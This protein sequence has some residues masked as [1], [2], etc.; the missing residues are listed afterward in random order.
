MTSKTSPPE[1]DGPDNLLPP[2][3]KEL[4]PLV[5]RIL[6]EPG[7]SRDALLDEISDGD[8][9]RREE[10]SKIVA[11]CERDSPLLDRPAVESYAG[12]F[13][14]ADEATLT[15]V[16]GDRYRIEREAGRGG[17]ARVFLARD[18][19][20]DRD[21]AVK[22][23]REELA[24]SL[25]SGRFLQEIAIA[26]RLRH[27]NIVPMYDSGEADGVLYFVMP[28]E[29]GPSLG[30]RM[31]Q[32]PAMS[33][34]E[35]ISILRDIARA[36]AYAHER[37]IV[38]RDIKPG[39]VLLT[40]GAAVV[41]DFG[42]AKAV[43]TAQ[44]AASGTNTQAD[45]PIGTPAYM[46]PEQAA[47]DP[48]TDHRADIYSFGCL[49]Y[50]LFS[51]S[52]PFQKTTTQEMATAH[53]GTIPIPILEVCS[54]VSAPVAVLIMSCLNKR[55]AD[56]PQSARELLNILDA[57][58][59]SPGANAELRSGRPGVRRF[60]PVAAAMVLIVTAGFFIVRG[61]GSPKASREL[62]VAVVPIVI[63]RDSTERELAFGLSDEIATALVKEPGVRV[64]SRR[65]VAASNDDSVV[66]PVK[67]G[68]TLGAEYLVTNSL[69]I[70][71]PRLTV[72]T[73]LVQ[74]NNGAILWGERFE[75][76]QSEMA[77]IREDIARSVGDTLRKRSGFSGER[78]PTR[79]S[80]VVAPEPYRLYLL[81]QRGLDSRG[82]S[83]ESSAERFR[84]ATQL[85]TLYAEAYAG[86]S[87]AL[88]LSPYF[89]PVSPTQVAAEA[90]AAARRALQL[91]PTL[92]QPHVALGIIN[93]LAYRW[94]SAGSEFRTGVALRSVS[95]VE[96]LVQFGRY[97][98]FR[99]QPA[100][101]EKQFKL[102][103]NTEPASALVRSWVAYSYYVEGQLDSAII[104]NRRAFQSDST[105]LTT[106]SLGALIL[107]NA[108]DVTGARNYIRRVSPRFHLAFY[109]L[110]ADGDSV[111]AKAR[112]R[113]LEQQRAAPWLVE[114]SRAFYFLGARDSAQ[115]ITAFERATDAHGIWPAT[116]AIEDP[117]F[118]PVRSNPRFQ[119]VLRRVGLRS[120]PSS[121]NK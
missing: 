56:R 64:M 90:T 86:L 45:S 100:E 109:V 50:E 9:A 58:V 89:K 37:G 110:G 52:A 57:D 38:H 113:E 114:V 42:I 47:G 76:N 32:D 97:L 82:Q 84:Q 60:I 11:E 121:V 62:T 107:L 5:D 4:A 23:I 119:R 53:A 44:A 70:R 81:A 13:S 65:G 20:H 118:D 83:I 2:N 41:S 101:A 96:P 49:A 17:M 30:A 103:L 66:D 14:D 106:L 3:W 19:K 61:T 94:D 98:L 87:L 59:S 1:A 85:D 34:V 105:N 88:A 67:T 48:L 116:E 51:G 102:A 12:L 79:P 31:K 91:D 21:V 111:I 68:R 80:R 7:E 36:L 28:Y 104:E 117:I 73:T 26:A 33:A 27:P 35:R 99:G 22:V 24:A 63:G 39:N 112:L 93:S 10:L 74:A 108:H 25:G 115:A 8:A 77:A 29:E 54:T 46:A 95:D 43:S 71:G 16:L 40:G 120:A 69:T 72:L 92:A 75:R 78:R 55:P 18:T 6:D 15:G